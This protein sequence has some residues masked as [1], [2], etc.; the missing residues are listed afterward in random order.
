MKTT[1]L[2]CIV[3]KMNDAQA[4]CCLLHQPMQLLEKLALIFP[5]NFYSQHGL[6]KLQ[7][8]NLLPKFNVKNIKIKLSHPDISDQIT[9]NTLYCV[10]VFSVI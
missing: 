7:I 4:M 10:S 5:F 1:T 9:Y 3:G 8:K 6:L 2:H